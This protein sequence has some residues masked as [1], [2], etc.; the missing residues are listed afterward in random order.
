MLA[1][2]LQTWLTH[3]LSVRQRL[4]R[5][6]TSYLLFLMVVTTRHSLEEAARFAGLH[7]SQFSKVLKYHSN[8]AISTLES[9]SKKQAK[10]MAK[11]LQKFKGLPGFAPKLTFALKVGILHQKLVEFSLAKTCIV[12]LAS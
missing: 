4:E 5:I 11:A 8:V 12:L 9:L 10:H 2:P 1:S 3:H 6:C 7:K